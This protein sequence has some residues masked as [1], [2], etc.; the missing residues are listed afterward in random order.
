MVIKYESGPPT[1]IPRQTTD[2]AG[3]VT[4]TTS[5]AEDVGNLYQ[6]LVPGAQGVGG[7]YNLSPSDVVRFISDN[8][9]KLGQK[10]L[11]NVIRFG[12]EVA[13]SL[14][15]GLKKYSLIHWFQNH[16]GFLKNKDNI[17]MIFYQMC[18]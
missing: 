13:H 11:G 3:N 9:I 5:Y 15:F 6:F 2:D 16:L 4:S 7:I 8:N 1:T 12:L 17:H 14:F 18:H 10:G